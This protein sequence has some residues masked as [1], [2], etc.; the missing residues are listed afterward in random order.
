MNRSNS[1]ITL[2]AV[3]GLLFVMISCNNAEN[4]AQLTPE[5]TRVIAKEAYIFGYP[6]VDNMRIQYAYFVDKENSDFKAP[7]NTIKNISRVY[8][9]DDKT[10]QTPNSDTPYSFIGLDLGHDAMVITIPEIEAERYWSLQLIDMYT[11]NFAYLG[12]RETGND[13]GDF[14]IAGPNWNGE[15]PEGIS[16]VIHSET[17]LALV[18]IRTQL[19]NAD[20]IEKVEQIQNK[21]LVQTLSSFV[22]K[23]EMEIVPIDFIKP[24][25]V[26]EQ[27]S[28]LEFYNQLNFQL[29]FIPTHPS[30][31][32]LMDRFAK[33][34]IVTGKPFEVDKLSLEMKKAFEDGIKDA[35]AEFAALQL[36]AQKGEITSGDIFGT[37]EILQN[38]YIYRMAGAVLGI[39]GNTQEEAIYPSYYVDEEGIPLNGAN[40]YSMYFA[41][42]Q[43]P[44]VNSFWSLTM[45]ELP[46]SLLVENPL[47]RY[48]MN[49]TMVS[50]FNTDPDGGITIFF[51]NEN[52]GNNKEANWLPSPKGP[53][54][55]VMR[56]YW[57]KEDALTGKWTNPVIEK[58]N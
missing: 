29:Q 20:E 22:G 46:A 27:K 2:F 8:T 31:V 24:L 58:I 10:V 42:G 15:V 43:L 44:P 14:M 35:W 28:S 3:F 54:S 40:K 25:G 26:D 36:L 16:Q 39:Y 37:R 1:I 9:P 18:I 49:S 53:F 33:V 57:P 48:L 32:A 13:G 30:E 5:E 41:P 12:S 23:P 6:I 19:F 17:E 52:P 45:Y 4:E 51:Q 11:H 55:V 50:Q 56:L 47:N 38:N 7:R 34:G 21:F